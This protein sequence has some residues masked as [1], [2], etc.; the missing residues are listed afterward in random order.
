MADLTTVSFAVPTTLALEFQTRA[1]ALLT[2]L[3]GGHAHAEPPPR[4]GQG[5]FT[6][7]ESKQVQGTDVWQLPHW[8]RDDQDRARW[9]AESLP[10]H[11]RQA[12]TVLCRNAGTWV[13]GT[14]LA[15]ELGLE[16]GAKS[17]PP[18]FKSMANRCRRV[19]RR[20]MWNYDNQQGYRVDLL[21]AELFTDVL[22]E[23]NQ[24]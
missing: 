24:T 13:S 16:H 23:L 21:V 18:S 4:E 9:V 8:L 20:P 17:V 19:E 7:L 6:P 22:D 11:P 5:G 14:R 10:T 2:E 15:D 12:L 1:Y 3:A